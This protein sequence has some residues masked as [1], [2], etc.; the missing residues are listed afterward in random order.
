MAV[1]V[2]RQPLAQ[3]GK[4]PCETFNPE[5]GDRVEPG[6]GG[7][8]RELGWVVEVGAGELARLTVRVLMPAG[9][10]VLRDDRD[11]VRIEQELPR[12]PIMKRREP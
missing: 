9:L 4:P 6:F 5:E 1:G 12:E 11:E 8:F 10:E 2:V 3:V 7:L